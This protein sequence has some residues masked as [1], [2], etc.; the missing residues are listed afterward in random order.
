MIVNERWAGDAVDAGGV[1]AQGDC[2][3]VIRERK[4][5]AQDERCIC[6]RQ[7]REAIH[8][9]AQRKNGSLRRYAPRN[10]GR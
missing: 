6:V 10:D 2:R 1:G 3:W 4:P 8:L 5:F 7:K 9:T